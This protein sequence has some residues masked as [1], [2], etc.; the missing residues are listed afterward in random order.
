[1]WIVV[2]L[3]WAPLVR[4]AATPTSMLSTS[5]RMLVCPCDVVPTV[6]PLTRTEYETALG[7]SVQAMVTAVR[8]FSMIRIPVAS[9]DAC[10]TA[11]PSEVVCGGS[12]AAVA[13][14]GALGRTVGR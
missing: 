13:V 14:G 3:C 7:T 6:L 9:L 2:I 8:V 12:A 11:D 10:G 1:M 4:R 5:Q